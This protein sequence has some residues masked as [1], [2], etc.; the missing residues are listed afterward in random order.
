MY[1]A[2][3]V[4]AEAIKKQRD[5]AQ[6]EMQN[7]GKFKYDDSAGYLKGR[8]YYT[9]KAIGAIE[10]GFDNPFTSTV[11]GLFDQIMNYADFSYDPAKDK[12][13]DMYRQQYQKIGNQ[14]MQNTI[15]QATA[16]T[17]GY[18]NSW[19]QAAG[20]QAYQNQMAQLGDRALE[21]YAAAFDRY[22]QKFEALNKQYDVALGAK[23]NAQQG[24]QDHVNN[25]FAAGNMYGDLFNGEYN[26]QYGLFS[27]RRSIAQ[28]NFNNANANY[29]WAMGYN[30]TER[31]NSNSLNQSD[32]QWQQEFNETKRHNDEMERAQKRKANGR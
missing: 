31:N 30:Q 28:D 3:Y 11:D 5:D 20:Q 29:T 2:N 15:G 4:D 25:L 14:L 27:D 32:Y 1:N 19:A 17:G 7:I 22:N 6:K 9:N 16:R 8:N 10:N 24:W 26:N 13:I 23:Q 18:N 12:M 21:R